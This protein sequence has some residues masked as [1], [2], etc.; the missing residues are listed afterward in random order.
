MKMADLELAFAQAKKYKAPFIG[1]MIEMGMARPEVIIN[2][3][4][5]YDE[6]LAYYRTR[7]N[8]DLEMKNVEF[9]RIIGVSYGN[10][11]MDIQ[12]ELLTGRTGE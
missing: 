4:D 3:Y 12:W 7:Y 1:V 6:K 11:Y 8:D 2:E 10:S 9:I 5:N